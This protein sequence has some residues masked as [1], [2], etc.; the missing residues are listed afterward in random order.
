MKG[1]TVR[2]DLQALQDWCLKRLERLQHKP[3]KACEDV[4]LAHAV[5]LREL[6]RRLAEMLENLP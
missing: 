4:W 6:Y 5:D 1:K 2:D 3:E